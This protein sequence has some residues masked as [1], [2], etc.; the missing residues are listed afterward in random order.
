MPNVG[1][2]TLFNLLSKQQVPA[3]NY[4]FCTI[5]PNT[6]RVIVPDARFDYLC[7]QHTP[8]SE[9]SASLTIVDIA[10]LVRGASEGRGLG[11]EFLSHINAVDAI[12]HVVRCFKDE[13]IEHVE[14]S[15]DPIRDLEII[16]EELRRKDIQ[17]LTRIVE[18]HASFL[19]RAKDKQKSEELEVFQRV[20]ACLEEGRD[21]RSAQWANK[22]IDVINTLHLLSTKSIVYLANIS[23]D[24][25]ERQRNKWLPRVKEWIDTHAAGSPLIPV[26]AAFEAKFAEM[27]EEAKAKFLSERPL[28]S[29]L[30]KIIH[31]GYDALNLIHFF[32]A[33]PDEVRCWTVRKLT[34]APQAAGVIHSD[35]E[36]GFIC[37][38]VM[39]FADFKELGSEAACKAAGK[40]RQQGKEYVVEDGDIIFFKF[41][42]SAAP[43][44]KTT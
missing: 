7:Q 35:F 4:A 6:A 1:K 23:H 27:D 36:K 42:V 41:N 31:A 19:R 20:M 16:H 30:P 18:G 33:G 10:G 21:I 29:Q 11:N 22:D 15:V 24:D 13:Q 2:S 5:D 12:Y 43:K 28:K 32:T 3:E 17:N 8:A 26:S 37:A 40:Y 25:F 34:K 14:G 9:V 44:K 39:S 38:E